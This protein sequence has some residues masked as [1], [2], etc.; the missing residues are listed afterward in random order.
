MTQMDLFS[1]EEL[2]KERATTH[3]KFSDVSRIAQNTKALWHSSPN[4]AK[5][6]NQQAEVLDMCAS[7]VGRILSGDPDYAD[8]WVDL[9][10]YPMLALKEF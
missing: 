10:G 2:L 5:L 6:T 9:S 3:G 8:H 7:K 1:T 4:W